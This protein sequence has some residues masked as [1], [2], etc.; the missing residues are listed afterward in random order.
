MESNYV[1]FLRDYHKC[2][3]NRTE[4]SLEFYSDDL[5][6]Y[7]CFSSISL[8]GRGIGYMVNL[9]SRRHSRS[10]GLTV[11]ELMIVVLIIGLLSALAVPALLGSAANMAR[12][13][14]AETNRR[15]VLRS[16]NV[17]HLGGRSYTVIQT[18]ATSNQLSG[19]PSLG[20]VVSPP[21]GCGTYTYTAGDV[22]PNGFK[23]EDSCGSTGIGDFAQQP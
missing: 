2:G 17:E 9:K 14:V 12:D 4:I 19:M 1:P 18:M 7:H 22:A 6:L 8:L 11:I 10:R 15:I 3:G 5:Y 21:P 23:I 16:V 20:T 13:Q